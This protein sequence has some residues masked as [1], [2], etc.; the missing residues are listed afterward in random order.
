MKMMMDKNGS[1]D[2]N[3]MFDKIFDIFKGVVNVKELLNPEK[4]TV[5]DRVFDL[6]NSIV[7]AIMEIAKKSPAQ[8]AADPLVGVVK[9]SADFNK[10]KEDPEM[11]KEAIRKWDAAHG[12]TKT[13][14]ILDT[15]GLKRPG[16][17]DKPAPEP[18]AE[19]ETEFEDVTEENPIPEVI[20]TPAPGDD[21]E[22]VEVEANENPME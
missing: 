16:A 14:I 1:G 13:D 3:Q 5:V 21:N 8:R 9:D 15:V 6:A 2:H 18:E 7:P 20:I 11:L 12:A 22:N 17:P 19:D 10:I 4:Q